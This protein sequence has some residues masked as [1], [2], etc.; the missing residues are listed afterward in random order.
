MI[1]IGGTTPL[2]HGEVLEAV[3]NAL[4]TLGGGVTTVDEGAGD[5]V[6]VN[7]TLP[8]MGVAALGAYLGAA[9]V[10]L[11]D[12]GQ[13]VLGGV[14]SGVHASTLNGTLVVR[15][16]GGEEDDDGDFR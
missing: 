13:A 8:A 5:S 4:E 14:S 2:T 3:R 9:G 6:V 15:L 7:F 1:I 10:T 16:E 12:A 11:D